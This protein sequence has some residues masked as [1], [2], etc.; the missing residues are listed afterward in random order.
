MDR[1]RPDNCTRTVGMD[2]GIVG[3]RS[4]ARFPATGGRACA[5]VD[6]D[7]VRTML[8]DHACGELVRHLQAEGHRVILLKGHT[9]A[10]WLYPDPA[11]RTYGDLDV[12]VN[13]ADENAVVETLSALGYRPVFD[14]AWRATSPEEQPLRDSRG[15]VIDLH[16]SI[17]GI[18]VP[19]Q[20]AW[21][22]LSELTVPWDWAGTPVEAL[23]PH[24]RAV[25]LAVH[26]AQ[27]G[28]ADSKAAHDLALGLERLDAETWRG[29]ARLARRLDALD[30]F[31]A[32][33]RL[34]PAGIRLA[35]D[36][37]LPEPQHLETRMRAD[38]AGHPAIV[39]ERVLIGRTW[40]ERAR[41]A[42]AHVFPSAV[43][44]R[45]MHPE[46][47]RSPGALLR[48]RVSRPFVLVGKLPAAI[49]TRSRF[50]RERGTRA[51]P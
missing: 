37:G 45:T 46:E 32:G 10:H 44:M 19:P 11:E 18:R 34:T 43:W 33:L 25:H 50:R 36:L 3:T 48:A 40:R 38:S 14:A 2:A 7:R 51:A 28:L 42:Y 41:M 13:P 47:T 24:A 23:A 20:Q 31:A 29:A 35:T 12:L 6:R 17:K 5:E 16:V 1:W 27:S 26:V 4:A 9:I 30:S 15:V 49:R 39:L 22:V 8:L 21:D